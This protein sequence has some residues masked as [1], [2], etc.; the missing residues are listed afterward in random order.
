M[1]PYLHLYVA[2]E[3]KKNYG[4]VKLS[5]TVTALNNSS[6]VKLALTRQR[7]LWVHFMKNSRRKAT[8]QMNSSECPGDG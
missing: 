2:S 8:Y 7:D 1:S 6:A 4:F 5:E 3:R